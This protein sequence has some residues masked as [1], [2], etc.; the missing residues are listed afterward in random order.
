MAGIPPPAINFAAP[1]ALPGHGQAL[2]QGQAGHGQAGQGQAQVQPL[3]A[4]A[5]LTLPVR[6][7]TFAG[8]YA[9]E[10]QDPSRDRYALILRRFDAIGNEAQDADT[11]LQ[12]TLGNPNV[13]IA[14]LCCATLS[15]APRIYVIHMPSKFSPSI[16]GRITP[17]DGRLFAFLGEI[18]RDNPMIVAFPSTGFELTTNNVWVWDDENFSPQLDLLDAAQLFPKLNAN[19]MNAISKRTRR[20]MYL[21]AKYVPLLL[22]NKGYH[23]KQAFTILSQAFAED[24]VL[25][26]ME[27]VI[28]WLR[29][30]LHATN[31]NNTGPPATSITLTAPFL[32]EDLILHRDPFLARALPGRHDTAPGLETAITT[33]ATAITS[34]TLEARTARIARDVEREQ[35]TTPSTKFG[36]LFDSLKS[37]LDVQEE[38]ELP[39]FW[40]QLAAAPKKQEFSIIKEY[41]NAHSRSARAFMP[42]SPI[43]SPKLHSDLMT[44]TFVG[45]HPDDLKTGIQ[46]FVVMDGSEQHRAA[47]LDLTRSFNLLF[48][49]EYGLAYADL[50]RFKLSKD[51]RSHPITFFEFERNLGMF[52]NLLDAILG[53]RHPLTTSFKTFWDS[54]Q[55]QHRLFLQTEI[56]IRKTI[57]PVHLL[58]NIH[59]IC[60]QWFSAKRA[61]LIPPTPAFG[62]ILHRIALGLYTTPNLPTDLYQ[63]IAPKTPYKPKSIFTPG[64]TPSV[65]TSET[66]TASQASSSM[67]TI[68]ATVATSRAGTFEAN[69]SPNEQLLNLLKPRIKIRELIGPTSPPHNDDQEPMCLSYHLKGGCY[70]NCKRR[71]DHTRTLS[72][73]EIT[74]LANYVADRLPH[75]PTRP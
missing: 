54:L 65:T 20:L 7:K 56:D 60:Y 33:M 21:P 22:D 23:P 63:L 15:T 31:N 47:A 39:D 67:S 28:T 17:W 44:V 16:D 64:L 50:D 2:G 35:P 75:L 52:G 72:A 74:R 66:D 29:I 26:D 51:L 32:D 8:Y 62:D 13:P 18:L 10:S 43:P 55:Q 30:S 49:R 9:D 69:P 45:D 53:I 70:S 68:T 57:K 71:S 24:N 19:A 58:Y 61:R 36:L 11:L 40:F 73:D 5:P 25:P 42:L 37:F 34:Q 14:F 59:L 12:V 3:P 41:L 38:D 27:P 46:P 4:V 1:A 48:E 6:H